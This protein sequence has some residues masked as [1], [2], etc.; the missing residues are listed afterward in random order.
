MSRK[1]SL[2]GKGVQNGNRVSHSKRRTRHS[3]LPNLHKKRLF[4]AE[5]KR[6]FTLRVSTKALRT[7]DK[8][9]LDA[10]CKKVGYLLK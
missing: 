4:S 2:T 6:F 10:Y 7:I 3:F 5:K 1:C 9:G 8:L